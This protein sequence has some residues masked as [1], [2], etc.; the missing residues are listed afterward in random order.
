[1]AQ[2]PKFGPKKYLT[3]E[4]LMEILRSDSED[5]HFMEN[6]EDE[7]DHSETSSENSETDQEAGEDLQ[8]QEGNEEDEQ[9]VQDEEIA[10]QALQAAREPK[11]KRKTA[12]QVGRTNRKKKTK[13]M[14]LHGVMVMISYHTMCCLFKTREVKSNSVHVFKLQ[15]NPV[16]RT[17]FRTVSY[18]E[19]VFKCCIYFIHNYVL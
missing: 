12:T 11:G 8:E 9:M 4:D 6:L 19:K 14:L 1:M 17:V 7:C 13:I 2:K 18:N 10:E 3:D 5:E 15:C 16:H